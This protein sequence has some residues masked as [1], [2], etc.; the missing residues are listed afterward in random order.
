MCK[1]EGEKK[2]N[3]VFQLN[4]DIF[5]IAA[6]RKCVC[7]SV[8]ELEVRKYAK[9]KHC[10][11]YIKR[12]RE[13]KYVKTLLLPNLKVQQVFRVSKFV[14]KLTIAHITI[15]KSEFYRST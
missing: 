12:E 15:N 3:I 6:V 14:K 11:S 7:V 5:T 10:H 2:N 4:I 13:K 1:F 8:C 9:C